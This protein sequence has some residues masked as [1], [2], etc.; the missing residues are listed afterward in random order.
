MSWQ[1]KVTPTPLRSAF[2]RATVKASDEMSVA[3]TLAS[4]SD[5]ANETAMQPLPVPTSHIR[6][7]EPAYRCTTICTNSSVSGLGISTA[8]DTVNDSP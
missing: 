4:F 3:K 1:A 5:F 6:G 8:G 7:A 2:P